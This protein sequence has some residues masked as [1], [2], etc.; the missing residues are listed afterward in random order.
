MKHLFRHRERGATRLELAIAAIFTALLAAVLLNRL[1]SYQ[2]E[3]E[4]VA[5][6]QLLGSLRTALA[7]QSARVISTTGEA[8][9][10][11]LSHQNPMTWLQR[12]PENYLGEYYSPNKSDLPAGNWYF[13]RTAKTLVYI[14]SSEKSFSSGTQKIMSF[15]V[16]LL[17][18]SGPGN[19]SGQTK[20]TTGLVIDQINDQAVAVNDI[21]GFGPPS[22]LSEK[23]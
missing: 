2:G 7:V 3:S 12:R 22:P 14:A 5:A 9:L 8:G 13:D 20:G 19:T 16:K 17:R 15:K 21:A 10:I 4:Q 6:K 1:T 11:A 18:V 23:K